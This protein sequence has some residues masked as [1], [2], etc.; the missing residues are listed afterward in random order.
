[1]GTAARMSSSLNTEVKVAD[2]PLTQMGVKGMKTGASGNSKREKR[3]E[4]Q[5]TQMGVKGAK[6]EAVATQSGK[7]G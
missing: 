6:I 1:M 4:R 7:I 3:V 5:L 2:R